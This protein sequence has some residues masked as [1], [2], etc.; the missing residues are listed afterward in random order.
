MKTPSVAPKSQDCH[1]PE[2]I[3]IG[4]YSRNEAEEPPSRP[5]IIKNPE[6]EPPS[7]ATG[8][9][10]LFRNVSDSSW[11]DWKWQFRNRITTI[12]QLSQLVALSIEEQAQITLVTKRYP[13]SITPYYLSLINP[14]DPDDPIRKQAIPSILEIT[15]SSMGL[16]DPLG[17][18]KTPWCPA[19][20]T[21]TRTGC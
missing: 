9:Y 13:L 14:D 4:N 8:R 11:K 19:W 18:K 3:T 15:M 7:T 21:A 5:L 6:E 17:E 1:G 2:K 10:K 16:E 20:S 12:D